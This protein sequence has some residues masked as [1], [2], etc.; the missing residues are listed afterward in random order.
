MKKVILLVF[1]IAASALCTY[2]EGKTTT[3]TKE[4]RGLKASNGSNPCKGACRDIC[5]SE[6]TTT[7]EL[8]S[9]TIRVEQSGNL[10]EGGHSAPMIYYLSMTTQQYLEKMMREAPENC[11]ITIVSESDD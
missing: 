2:V 5:Y 10:L 7:E 1:C 6:T 11:E 9:G 4:Y 3:T 8:V